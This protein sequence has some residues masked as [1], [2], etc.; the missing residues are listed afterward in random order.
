MF[1]NT[2]A[3]CV[4]C[5]S[6]PCAIYSYEQHICLL[7]IFLCRFHSTAQCGCILATLIHLD[8]QYSNAFDVWNNSVVL[9]ASFSSNFVGMALC[10]LCTIMTLRA[11]ECMR[12]CVSVCREFGKEPQADGEAAV[13]AGERPWDFLVPWW[14]Q[15][16]VCHKWQRHTVV[17]WQMNDPMYEFSRWW[18][19]VV[20]FPPLPFISVPLCCEPPILLRVSFKYTWHWNERG[21][22]QLRH[23]NALT[24][25]QGELH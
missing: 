3:N 5:V 4:F 11:P 6:P 19:A 24:C 13:A 14:P 25:G 21:L 17:T 1:N 15:W 18:A 8:P 2:S 16:H 23:C 12:V 7:S 20:F 10:V 22:G 9:S